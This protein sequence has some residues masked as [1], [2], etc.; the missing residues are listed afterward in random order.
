MD[1][2]STRKPLK[3]HH[4]N[5]HHGRMAIL[6]APLHAYKQISLAPYSLPT[7][8]T[9]CTLC[10]R[11]PLQSPLEGL[12]L[13]TVGGAI[14]FLISGMATRT[15]VIFFC[16]AT[17]KTVDAHCGLWLPDLD[18]EAQRADVLFITIDLPD[19]KNLKL[20]IEP[21]GKFYF[22][23][24]ARTDNTYLIAMVAV[25]KVSLTEPSRLFEEISVN[26]EPVDPSMVDGRNVPTEAQMAD[27]ETATSQWNH[28]KY[29]CRN[30]ILYALDDSLYDIYSTFASCTKHICNSRRMFVSYQKVNKLEPMFMGNGTSLKIEGKGKFILKLTSGKDL[31]LSNVL[32]VP[33]ITKNL[34]SGPI[35]SNKGFKLVI[36]SYKFVITKGDVYVGKGYLC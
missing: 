15:A 5:V 31:V 21:E 34:I 11:G 23:A 2:K 7:S 25:E 9:S 22:S 30:Y 10:N 1:K 6:C 27:Y 16:F 8:Q 12:L 14:S 24:T 26:S 20:K 18:L 3:G 4:C 13:D 33:N 36:E 32:H 19:A 29:N 17:M 35:L 28:N